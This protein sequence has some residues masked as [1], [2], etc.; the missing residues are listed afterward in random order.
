M[1]RLDTRAFSGPARANALR[2]GLRAR[3]HTVG[4]VAAIKSKGNKQVVFSRTLIV[5]PENM[6]TVTDICGKYSA[7]MASKVEDR[8]SGVVSFQCVRDTFDD[9]QIHFW[10]RYEST[11]SFDKCTKDDWMNKFMQQVNPYLEA[12]VGLAL[13]EWKNGQISSSCLPLGPKGEGGLD[14]AT[15]A[16]G[17]GGAS[18]KRSSAAIPVVAALT[19]AEVDDTHQDSDKGHGVIGYMN[20]MGNQLKSLQGF[21]GLKK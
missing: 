1:L 6:K 2:K 11:T 15:G 8:S 20:M 5:K 12:P 9:K 4:V 17:T 13:Y 10:E 14:D 21:F 16:G 19:D 3:P 18:M 7:L